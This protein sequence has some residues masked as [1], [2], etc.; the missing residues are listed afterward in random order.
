[1]LSYSITV[2]HG[3]SRYVSSPIELVSLDRSI[4]MVEHLMRTR[5][6]TRLIEVGSSLVIEAGDRAYRFD[7]EV[8]VNPF[9]YGYGDD[10]DL[11]RG[12]DCC[13]HIN[14]EA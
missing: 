2:I 10:E 4:E 13:A 6:V 8:D 7:V 1:M 12:D 5:P 14:T 9:L 3:D 11:D